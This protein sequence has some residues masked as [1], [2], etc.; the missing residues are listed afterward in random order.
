MLW[1]LF[2]DRVLAHYIVHFA[3]KCQTGA[4]NLRFQQNQRTTK[5][6]FQVW[7]YIICMYA[8]MYVYMTYMICMYFWYEVSMIM[9]CVFKWSMESKFLWCWSMWGRYFLHWTLTKNHITY[10]HQFFLFQKSKTPSYST[11]SKS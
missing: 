1:S 7:T 11:F 6:W 10:M 2:T 9:V 8:C 5:H 4:Q 3:W